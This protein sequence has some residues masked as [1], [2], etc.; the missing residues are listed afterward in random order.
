MIPT[1]FAE[2]IALYLRRPD[3]ENQYLYSQIFSGLMYVAASICMW[4]LRAWKLGEND[5][6]EEERAG[7]SEK[8]KGF[9]KETGRVEGPAQG[10]M[11]R[12]RNP[13]VSRWVRFAR[14]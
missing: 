12:W 6:K 9:E 5:R 1:L 3:F 4:L 7:S 14:V 10:I 2:P 13:T 8:M 11:E